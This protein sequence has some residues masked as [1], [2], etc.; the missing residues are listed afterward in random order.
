VTTTLPHIQKSHTNSEINSNW[1]YFIVII[2]I[3]IIIMI[4]MI[5]IIIIIIILF[6]DG[7]LLLFV[8]V[9]WSE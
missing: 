4:I 3:M 1:D 2:I 6:C 7:H 9:G 8:L 5:I